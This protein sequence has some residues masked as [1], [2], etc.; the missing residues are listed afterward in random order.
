MANGSSGASPAGAQPD[1]APADDACCGLLTWASFLYIGIRS[2]K[3]AW[4]D[5][6]A[7]YGLATIVY[8][9][10]VSTAP[11][12]APTAMVDTRGEAPPG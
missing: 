1:V 11:E 3:R 8:V 12:N 6:A 5:A 10:I 4:L 2:R 7:G 9:A